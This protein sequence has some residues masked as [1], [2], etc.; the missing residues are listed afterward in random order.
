MTLRG[1]IRNLE[2][3]IRNFRVFCETCFKAAH[4]VFIS[5]AQGCGKLA[6]R[7]PPIVRL[8]FRGGACGKLGRERSFGY[9]EDEIEEMRQW[10]ELLGWDFDPLMKLINADVNVGEK[11]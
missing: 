5:C 6:R 11:L 9:S 7:N 8:L 3:G 1:E 10:A 4:G 2:L